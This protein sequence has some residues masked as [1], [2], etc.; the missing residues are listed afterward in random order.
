MKR[1]LVV[2]DDADARQELSELLAGVG[3]DVNSARN[4]RDGLKQAASVRFDLVIT[5]ILMPDMEGL[6]FILSIKKAHPDVKIVAISGGGRFKNMSFLDI[7]KK[8]GADRAFEKPLPIKQLLQD[9]ADLMSQSA[10]A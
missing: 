10:A 7:A 9:V 1:V 3:F 5:D 4:G 8:F 2:D 6:E